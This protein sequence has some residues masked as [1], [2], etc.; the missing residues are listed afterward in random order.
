MA[1]AIY[2][3]NPASADRFAWLVLPLAAIV[4]AVDL[5]LTRDEIIHGTPTSTLLTQGGVFAAYLVWWTAGRLVGTRASRFIVY[6]EPYTFV[7][8]CSHMITMAVLWGPWSLATGGYYNPLYPI[9]FFALPFVTFPVG[10][11]ITEA[12]NRFIPAAAPYFTGGRG[13]S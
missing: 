5:I 7:V 6:W 10:M 8:F 3:V 11:L 13:K 4:M 2:K 9:F 12:L 1:I